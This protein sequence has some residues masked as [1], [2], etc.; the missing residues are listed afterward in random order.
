M[1]YLDHAATSPLRPEAQQAMQPWWGVPANP[2]SVHRAGQRAAAAVEAARASVA[3]LVHGRP[4]GVVFTSGAT[5][6]NHLAIAGAA[7]RHGR[8]GRWF[9]S[10]IEHPCVL[11]AVERLEEQGWAVERLEVGPNGVCRLPRALPADT[12]GLSLMA[13]NHETGVVQPTAAAI[14]LG[15]EAGAFVHIDATQAVGKLDLDL[16]AADAVV[17]SSHKIGGP[18]GIGALILRDGE[19]FPPLL[20]GGAQERGRR[21]GTVP[22]ALVVGFGAAAECA[23]QERL[24]KPK[25]WRSLMRDLGHSMALAGGAAA[26]EQGMA[27]LEGIG[28]SEGTSIIIPGHAMWAFAGLRGAQLVQALDLRGICVSSGAAC[29]SGSVEPSPVLTAMGH[30]H[31][32]GG[33]RVSL[34]W[35][36]TPDEVR[37]L[38]DVIGEVVEGI[39][40]AAEFE[41]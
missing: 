25:I 36:T 17:C 26:P 21:A 34:G 41:M 4:E 3:E 20:P 14:A 29:A 7:R 11:A 38:A 37:A 15:A 13:V 33:L 10:P 30:A 28:E 22:T 23:A 18:P 31:P 16:S 32:D 24:D 27:S 40:L 8:P 39:R 19:P 5:E 9:V 2:A 1:I 6:A 12:V 35:S